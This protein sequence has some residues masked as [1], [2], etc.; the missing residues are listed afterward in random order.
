MSKAAQRIL[1]GEMLMRQGPEVLR[2]AVAGGGRDFM[3]AVKDC[4]RCQAFDA[5]QAWLDSGAEDGYEAFCPS[6]GYVRYLKA[7]AY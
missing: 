2:M 6:A 1:L 7:L 3:R 5:C 4:T